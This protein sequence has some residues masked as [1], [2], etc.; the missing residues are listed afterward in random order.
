MYGTEFEFLGNPE[1]LMTA[2]DEKI[3][4]KIGEV[5]NIHTQMMI[6]M[7]EA[8][9]ENKEAIKKYFQEGDKKDFAIK[10][11]NLNAFF[12]LTEENG[13]ISLDYMD[14]TD[15]SVTIWDMVD[16]NRDNAENLLDGSYNQW[17]DAG[18]YMIPIYGT[19]R[20]GKSTWRN[21]G[22]GHVGQ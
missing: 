11:H 20:D 13:N 15:F 4:Q 6:D 1:A 7:K 17:W 3:E 12:A 22:R 5:K 9:R 16:F 8:V 14:E 18:S 10:K 2:S 21:F 19:W